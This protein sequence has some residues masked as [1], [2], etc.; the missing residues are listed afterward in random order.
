MW[1]ECGI[2]FRSNLIDRISGKIELHSHSYAHKALI[3]N[4][5]FEMVVNGNHSLVKSGDLVT[6]KANDQH[7]FTCVSKGVEP[8]EVLCFWGDNVT[9]SGD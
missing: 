3:R 9:S 1:M 6:V 2:Q 4:G 7:S 5:S 8:A